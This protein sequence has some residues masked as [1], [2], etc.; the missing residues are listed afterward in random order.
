M[1]SKK[2]LIL[3]TNDD[4]YQARGIVSLIEAMRELGEII[5]FA[6]HTHRSG[7]AGAITAEHALRAWLHTKEEGLTMYVCNGTPADCVK[8]ALNEFV[9]R[10]PDLLVSGINH[11]SNAAISVI[12]SGTVE[13]PLK[14]LFSMSL[15]SLIRSAFPSRC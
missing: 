12:Y 9:D 13:Q 4:G 2:P 11:G 6:P 14:G 7:M 15:P 10:K 1:R 3:I 8:L 5:V